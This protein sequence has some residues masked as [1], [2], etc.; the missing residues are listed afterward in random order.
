LG[1]IECQALVGTQ[2]YFSLNGLMHDS[3]NY[4]SEA[5]PEVSNKQRL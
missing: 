4:V 5:D 3:Q 1:G 2:Y